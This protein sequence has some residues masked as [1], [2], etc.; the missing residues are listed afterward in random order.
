MSSRLGVQGKLFFISDSFTRG[1]P[2]IKPNRDRSSTLILY[3]TSHAEVNIRGVTETAYGLIRI[4]K[5]AN[6][7]R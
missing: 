7:S 2:K 6:W 5:V 4:L 1:A 3:E